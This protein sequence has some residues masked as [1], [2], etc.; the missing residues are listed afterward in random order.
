MLV[1]RIGAAVTGIVFVT[2]ILAMGYFAGDQRGLNLAVEAVSYNA[3]SF[4]GLLRNELQQGR[5]WGCPQTQ[6]QLT[7]QVSFILRDVFRWMLPL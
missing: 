4:K 6:F 1:T 2:Q 7:T 5:V 3:Y